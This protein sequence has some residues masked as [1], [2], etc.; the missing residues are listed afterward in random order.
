M[1]PSF[2]PRNANSD[3]T[4]S[5]SS[6][7]SNSF[8]TSSS[9]SFSSFPISQPLKTSKKTMEEVW[10]NINLTYLDKNTTGNHS[11]FPGVILQD[12]L[13]TPRKDHPQ[14]SPAEVSDD[15]MNFRPATMLSLNSSSDFQF[16]NNEIST[17]QNQQ[18]HFNGLAAFPSPAVS[19]PCNIFKKRPPENISGDRRHKRMI[20]NRESA[21]R[22]RARK[23]ESLFSN[24]LIF[25]I[26]SFFCLAY[27]QELEMEVDQL[28]EENARLKKQQ[29][30]QLV[31]DEVQFTKMKKL[32]RTS[33]APF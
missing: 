25:L 31:T 17:R 6:T 7:P 5:S 20:K 22:S 3:S 10:Q 28:R 15:L 18:P 12:F 19:S 2:Q 27:T 14:V 33:T 4:S 13:A 32:Y 23:Q 29:A 21:A 24:I 30:N 11:S 8:S 16:L 1:R 9:S 26:I